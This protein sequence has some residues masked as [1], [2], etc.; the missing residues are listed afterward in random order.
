MRNDRVTSREICCRSPVCPEHLRPV[1]DGAANVDL[2]S[3]RRV[4]Q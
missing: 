2:A 3:L 1:G 4:E